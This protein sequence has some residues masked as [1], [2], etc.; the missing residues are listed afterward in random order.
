M[1]EQAGRREHQ[2]AYPIEVRFVAA[3]DVALSASHGRDTCYIAVHQD[4]K[5]DWEPYFRESRRSWT[6]T[7]GDHTGQAPLP[8]RRHARSRYPLWGEFQDLRAKLDPGGLFSNPYTDRVLGPIAPGPTRGRAAGSQEGL[9]LAPVGRDLV[10]H[11]LALDQIERVEA[12]AQLAGLGVAQIHPVADAQHVLRRRAAG[13]APRPRLLAIE[14]KPAGQVRLGQ[15][16]A[17]GTPDAM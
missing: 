13:S 15:A 10:D 7:A 1:L 17:A 14:A 9:A 12:L 2:V 11:A 4:R 6:P 5:L 8:D 3:D 16:V